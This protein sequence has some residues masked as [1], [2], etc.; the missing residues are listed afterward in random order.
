MLLHLLRRDPFSVSRIQ[1]I[2]QHGHI[3]HGDIR[4]ILQPHGTARGIELPDHRD[5]LTW[6]GHSRCL[7][8]VIYPGTPR[9]YVT[10]RHELF[11]WSDGLQAKRTVVSSVVGTNRYPWPGT[12]AM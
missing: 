12:V 9:R 4:I 1:L 7:G 2:N 3:L 6:I 11:Q 5:A 8:H 10:I